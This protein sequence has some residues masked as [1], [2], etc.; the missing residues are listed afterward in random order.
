VLAKSWGVEKLLGAFAQ[1]LFRILSV[2]GTEGA[3]VLRLWG[4]ACKEEVQPAY[5]DF[6]CGQIGWR[7]SGSGQ[8]VIQEAVDWMNEVL[9]VGL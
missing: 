5:Q 7:E 9:V 8:G 3:D 6:G 2:G 4:K 1:G